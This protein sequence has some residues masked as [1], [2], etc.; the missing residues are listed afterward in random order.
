MTATI[1]DWHAIWQTVWTA[2]AAGIGVTLV[3]SL[4]VVGVTRSSDRRRRDD[5]TGAALFGLLALV[6]LGATLAAVAYA[7]TLIATK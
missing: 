2:A 3:F 4:A 1:V 7:I 5:A 6:A